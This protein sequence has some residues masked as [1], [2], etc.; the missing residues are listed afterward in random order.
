[1]FLFF[2]S[3][4]NVGNSHALWIFDEFREGLHPAACSAA[5]LMLRCLQWGV[6][7][8]ATLVTSQSIVYDKV[9]VNKPDRKCPQFF[10]MW[11]I[12]VYG[13]GKGEKGW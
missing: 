11:R 5:R 6:E 2:I 9:T 12:E 10:K 13:Y 3:A 4:G 7:L 1:M 8:D